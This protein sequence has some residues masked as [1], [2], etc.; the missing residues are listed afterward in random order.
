MA[1]QELPE[2]LRA[3]VL[4]SIRATEYRRARK[5]VAIAAIT[6]LIS[7]IGLILAT[8]SLTKTLYASE[9]YSYVTLVFSD[10]DVALGYWKYIALALAESL[11][12]VAVVIAL[13]FVLTA[14]ASIRVIANN[15]RMAL[16]PSFNA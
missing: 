10:P 8:I 15:I 12:V 7:S 5:Y 13:G 9:F 1:M 14:L 2:R 4:T 3:S 6:L 11:P 16:S